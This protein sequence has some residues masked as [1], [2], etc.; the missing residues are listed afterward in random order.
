MKLNPEVGV[1]DLRNQLSRYIEAV[2]GGAEVV[3]TDHGRA[4][5]RIVPLDGERVLDRLVADGLVTAARVRTR[6][7]PVRR[8]A[9]T[10]PVSEL[11]AEQRR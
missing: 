2:R 8:A 4:V 3:V 11:L 10:R 5:A 9:A 7:R 1:R 6:R